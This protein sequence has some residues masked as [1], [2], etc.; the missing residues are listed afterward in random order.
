[1]VWEGPFGNERLRGE[2][3][4]H[5]IVR[6]LDAANERQPDR[7]LEAELQH[8][9]RENRDAGSEDFRATADALSH[10]LQVGGE[11]QQTPAYLQRF[12]SETRNR[13]Q[14]DGPTID[15]GVY[16]HVVPVVVHDADLYKVCLY[17]I[18]DDW[19]RGITRNR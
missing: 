15:D 12:R 10:E 11:T 6:P 1:M 17:G 7:V 14:L 18:L 2:W 16:A 13:P 19:Y 5:R 9:T 3:G 8:I 4:V